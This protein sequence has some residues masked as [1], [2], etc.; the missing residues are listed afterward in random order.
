MAP[1][2]E[3]PIAVGDVLVFNNVGGYSVVY[4]PQFIK[5]QSAMF[6]LRTDGSV[7]EIMR[8][9]KFEDIFGKFSFDF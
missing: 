4:K 2:F 1:N 5:P 9:E 7:K 3:Q 6:V 8:A